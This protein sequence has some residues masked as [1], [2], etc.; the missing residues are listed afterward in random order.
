MS[1]CNKDKTLKANMRVRLI[2]K[3]QKP[4]TG[5][6]LQFLTPSKTLFITVSYS[7]LLLKQ[8]LV[9]QNC[10]QEQGKKGTTSVSS[11]VHNSDTWVLSSPLTSIP[12]LFCFLF[13]N[14]TLSI[15][16]ILPNDAY[17]LV[18]TP[19]PPPAHGG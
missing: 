17:F 8:T 6:K 19:L 5:K 2:C 18:K 12:G 1:P 9:F 14:P 11:K 13:I 7:L 16:V 10:M 3:K 4:Q 15:L